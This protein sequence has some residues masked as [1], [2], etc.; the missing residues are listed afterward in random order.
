M[1]VLLRRSFF[2]LSACSHF[3]GKIPDNTTAPDAQAILDAL[4]KKNSN[5]KTFKGVGR[6][7]IWN[8]KKIYL[9]ERVAWVGWHCIGPVRRGSSKGVVRCASNKRGPRDPYRTTKACLGI[10]ESYRTLRCSR[11]ST[12]NC[13]Q[14]WLGGSGLSTGVAGETPLQR[15]VTLAGKAFMWRDGLSSKPP[16]PWSWST[17][18]VRWMTA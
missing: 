18:G 4:K 12:G 10:W 17:A 6:I 1:I 11:S 14:S 3:P 9:S 7:R 16:S 2:F 15:Y 5:L 13:L 8:N